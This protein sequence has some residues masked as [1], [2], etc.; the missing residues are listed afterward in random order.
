MSKETLSE[1]I[2]TIQKATRLKQGEISVQAG[3]EPETLAQLKSKP[4]KHE[5]AI[6]RLKIVF[7]D[8]LKKSI[9]NK[10]Y[11]LHKA[12]ETFQTGEDDLSNISYPASKIAEK[13]LDEIANMLTNVSSNLEYNTSRILMNEALLRTGLYY[14]A[15]TTAR[16]AKHYKEIIETINKSVVAIF[17]DVFQ[18]SG[19]VSYQE[20]VSQGV[21]T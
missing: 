2:G 12:K 8:V 17:D 4:D 7:K 15:Q 19:L 21:S 5:A 16:D 14:H 3:Y 1:L 20:D 9:N 13:K 11:E 6:K 18:K 10:N